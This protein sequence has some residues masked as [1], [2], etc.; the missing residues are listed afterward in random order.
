MYEHLLVALDG[1]EAAE[2]VL[3]HVEA[4]AEAFHSQV[5]LLTAIASL[6]TVVAAST[7]SGPGDSTGSLAPPVDATEL[8]EAEQSGSSDYLTGLAN[9][10]RQKGLKVNVET[11]EGDAADTITERAQALGV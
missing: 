2:H 8:V 5:T 6:E 9:R 7:M 10:L 11:P 3:P 1:S 4:L